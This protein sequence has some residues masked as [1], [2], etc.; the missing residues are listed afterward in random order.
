M[1]KMTDK[2]QV[3]PNLFRHPTGQTDQQIIQKQH[4]NI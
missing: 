1:L 3:M 4:D 2:K